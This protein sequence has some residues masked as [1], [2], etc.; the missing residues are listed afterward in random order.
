MSKLELPR[1][2][3]L[4]GNISALDITERSCII[5]KLHQAVKLI[6]DERSTI[7]LYSTLYIDKC[8]KLA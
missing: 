8:L 3:S 4:K 7:Y 5:S 6:I 1:I 2:L